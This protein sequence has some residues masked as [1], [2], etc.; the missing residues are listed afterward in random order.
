MKADVFF[1][2]SVTYCTHQF[3]IVLIFLSSG[4]TPDDDKLVATTT[5]TTTAWCSDNRKR[6]MNVKTE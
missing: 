2:Q 4:N 3:A 6:S 1:N 5:T